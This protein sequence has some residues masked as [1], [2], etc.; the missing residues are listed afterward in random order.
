VLLRIDPDAPEPLFAQLAT[1][2][3]AA[4]ARGDLAAGERLPAAR[5]VAAALDVNVHTVLK[6]YQ[7]LRDER[8]IDLRPGRGAVVA[9]GAAGSTPPLPA[10]RDLVA[11]ARAAGIGPETLTALVKEE[12]R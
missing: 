3:R 8:L 6:A 5:D 7:E 12:Y 9:A 4:I 10:I 1:S 2:V 11:R